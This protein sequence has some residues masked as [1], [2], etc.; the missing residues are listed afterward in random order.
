MIHHTQGASGKDIAPRQPGGGEKARS[1]ATDGLPRRDS[2]L[3]PKP[4]KQ[5]FL[6]F[7]Q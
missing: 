7:I 6:L 4:G 2:S 1:R 3:V 5:L